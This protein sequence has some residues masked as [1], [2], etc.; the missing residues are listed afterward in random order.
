MYLYRHFDASGPLLYIGVSLS[1]MRRL[2]QHK[3]CS[4]WFKTISNITIE[5]FPT[6]NDALKAERSAILKEKPLYNIMGSKS[7]PKDD[8]ASREESRRAL[9]RRIVQFK[10]VYSLIEAADTLLISLPSIKK[11]IEEE[12][13]G[14]IIIRSGTRSSK[15]G[16]QEYKIYAIT[17]WQIVEYLEYLESSS[18]NREERG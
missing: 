17:G 10:P 16:E 6:R 9:L 7:D 4:S 14:H 8:A 13:L 11:L 15:N 18:T 12:K 3:D 1:V 2:E 5:S